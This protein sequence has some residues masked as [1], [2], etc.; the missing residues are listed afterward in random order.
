MIIPW[1]NKNGCLVVPSCTAPTPAIVIPYGSI[2]RYDEKQIVFQSLDLDGKAE[3]SVRF[4]N[5]DN[6]KIAKRLCDKYVPLARKIQEDMAEKRKV[7][8]YE[9][10]EKLTEKPDKL[11]A[12]VQEKVVKKVTAVFTDFSEVCKRITNALSNIQKLS[13]LHDIDGE[14]WFY[15]DIYVE[16]L[17]A[18]TRVFIKYDEEK[19]KIIY[20]F[21]TEILNLGDKE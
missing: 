1:H 10:I 2:L 13:K 17:D 6:G 4:Y 20:R 14:Q 15:V 3:K 7:D 8:A 19:G 9:T 21:L 12:E 16:A 5:A 11:P 18:A